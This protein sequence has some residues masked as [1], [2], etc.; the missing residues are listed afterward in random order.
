[1][2]PFMR[3]VLVSSAALCATCRAYWHGEKMGQ[4]EPKIK[5]ITSQFWTLFTV[6]LF[7]QNTAFH[8][9][10]SAPPPPSSG[11][12]YSVGP[13][14]QDYFLSLETETSS[15]YWVQLSN[16]HLKTGIDP[17]PEMFPFTQENWRGTMYRT[18]VNN[19]S[20]V[21]TYVMCMGHISNY[22]IVG[23]I[24]RLEHITV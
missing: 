17:V 23:S 20:S 7:I 1:M 18:V 5:F 22:L 24:C 19:S 21:S 11:G 6:L 16:H 9:L 15:I 13:K 12:H 3:P 10:H 8:R 14:R 2:W 4:C